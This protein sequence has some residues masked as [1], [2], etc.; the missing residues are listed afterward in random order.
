[1]ARSF[2]TSINLNKNELQNAVVQNLGS[3]PGSPTEGQIYYDTSGHTLYVRTNAGWRDVL[4]L[5]VVT[6]YAQLKDGTTTA[7]AGGTD[8]IWYRTSGTGISVTV[9]SNDA[10]YGDN[11]L[12]SID[13]ATTGA[14]KVLLT[15]GGGKVASSVIT[16]VLA[17]TDLTDVAAKTGTGTTV[18]MSV[19]ATLTNPIILGT[20]GTA[21]GTLNYS[22][23][24]LSVGTGSAGE[25]IVTATNTL[26]LSNK[27]LTTPVIGSFVNATHDH[28]NSAGGGTLTHAAISDFDTQVRTSRLDQMAAPT[29]AV[30]FNSQRIT[31]VATPTSGNDAA[32]KTYVDSLLEGR[33]WK[34]SVRLATA[35]SLPANTRTS[36]VITA[37]ANGGLTVDG[38]AVAVGNRIL[39][40]DEAT[41]ANNGVYDVTAI[42][43]ASNPF[44][45]TRSSDADASS[46]V[47]GGFAIWVNEGTANADTGWV[48]TTN[49]AITLNTTAL[50]FTQNSGLGQV[51]AGA[52]LTKS[53]NTLDIGTASSSRIVVNSD[54]IDLA[55]VGTAGT[56]TSV[57]T[58]AYGRVTAGAD[59][60]TS[61]GLVTR[62]G[63][64]AFTNRSIAGTSGRITVSNGSGAAGNP[65]VDLESGVI[66]AGTTDG[67]T[68]D[69][70]GRVTAIATKRYE[71]DIGDGSTTSI[72]VTHNLGTKAVSVNVWDNTT[73]YGDVY[74]DVRRTTTNTV[75]LVFNPAPS[76]NQYRVSIQA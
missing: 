70:Y 69:T 75:T 20:G 38:S 42:G 40:K 32:T 29:G 54:N 4:E 45:L 22:S 55:T 14:N 39:V 64:G 15:D 8:P 44:V 50:V 49:D 16:E 19:G 6:A 9:G 41:G 7:S 47:T 60:I 18:V 67:I 65:T 1:M 27:T 33:D 31:S 30:S 3:A 66:T 63:S 26:T 43:D 2:F 36:N 52:G 71:T 28:T 23:G 5:G 12:I 35:A 58:D 73:P 10:T 21:G 51:I 68:V 46:D 61:N 11:V 25:T 74:P 37:S 13:S 53:G 76:T 72:A 48:L 17:V 34:N 57:T 59:I 62:T 24:F 56:Y